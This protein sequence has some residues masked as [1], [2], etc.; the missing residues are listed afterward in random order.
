MQDFLS[1]KEKKAINR[2]FYVLSLVEKY[3]R[4]MV[5]RGVKLGK[6]ISSDRLKLDEA[7]I[8]SILPEQLLLDSRI[9]TKS[10]KLLNSLINPLRTA[11]KIIESYLPTRYRFLV[12]RYIK[13]IVK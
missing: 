10:V 12:P 2:V 11:I 5:M 8:L 7:L 13:Q 4:V 1:S 3:T 9:V 6:L